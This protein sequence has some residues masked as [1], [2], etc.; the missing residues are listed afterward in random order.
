[1]FNLGLSYQDF[2]IPNEYQ[3]N[4]AQV[5]QGVFT[6]QPEKKLIQ[7]CKGAF[8]MFPVLI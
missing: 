3:N 1:M 5:F 6:M 2:Q 7:V 4:L 8:T